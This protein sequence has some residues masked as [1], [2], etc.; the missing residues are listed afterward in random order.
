MKIAYGT[1][2]LPQM[3]LEEAF[4][5]LAEMG[6]DGVEI[7]IGPK[8]VGAML[9]DFSP[10]RREQLRAMLQ[11]TGL[12]LPAFMVYGSVYAPDRDAHLANLEAMRLYAQLAR[13][14]GMAEPPVLACGFGGRADDWDTIKEQMAELLAD[15]AQV[16]EEED[17]IFA[18]EAHSGAAVDRSERIVWLLDE[19]DHPRVR[20]HFDI[21]HLFLAGEPIDECVRTLVLYTAHTHI[22]DARRHPDGSRD[23]L[24]LGDGDLDTVTYLRAMA[25]AGWDD[26]ITLEVSTLI[27]GRDDY[28]PMA[29][30]IYSY[31]TLSTAFE[32]AGI[33]RT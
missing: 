12:G 16:A 31:E 6:Y 29:A 21:V 9:E 23:L 22:M 33:A 25:E 30:A 8:H 5:R 7:F 26:F 13:E 18:G 32:E 27:W 28:D 19:V 20:L 24:L 11:R 15:Y 1:Y 10:A 4:P 17:F 3:S 2:A 14:L